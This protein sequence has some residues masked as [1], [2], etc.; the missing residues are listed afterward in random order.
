MCWVEREN[1]QKRPKQ[2]PKTQ[3]FFIYSGPIWGAMDYK[4]RISRHSAP[5]RCVGWARQPNKV[6]QV[7]VIVT[8]ANMSYC[9]F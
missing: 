5:C 3:F 8:S 7:D 1:A 6:R 4:A 9:T 2:L